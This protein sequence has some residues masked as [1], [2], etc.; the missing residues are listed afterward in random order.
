MASQLAGGLTMSCVP[1]SFVIC[2][3]GLLPVG[4][5][6]T[7]D[8]IRRCVIGSCSLQSYNCRSFGERRAGCRRLL[9]AGA[10]SRETYPD[11]HSESLEGP[12]SGSQCFS[13]W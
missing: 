1:V 10:A 7:A 5:A 12:Q 3:A 8:R 6:A 4:A 2:G 13:T 11:E 9:V